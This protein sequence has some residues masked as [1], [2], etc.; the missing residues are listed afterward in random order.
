M[1]SC[2]VVDDEPLALSQMESYVKK[3]KLL[4]LKGCFISAV[5]ALDF[6]RENHID[7]L[8]VDIN[9]PELTGFELVDAIPFDVKKVFT[10]AYR[11]FALEGFQADAADYLL[12]PISYAK[13]A[14]SVEKVSQRYFINK[15]QEGSSVVDDSIFVRSEYKSIRIDLADID[16]IESKKE[17]M[18]I[19]LSSGEAITTY[20]SLNY[21]MRKL[22]DK[23][24]MRIHR[25]YVINKNAVKVV[26]RNN[27]VFGKNAVPISESAKEEFQKFIDDNKL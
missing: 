2:I 12:K 23:G 24:F 27:I 14:K 22:A 3:S 1:I 25:S 5:E 18:D 19:V 21:L 7:L 10:T 13:F 4:D 6:I 9:M 17:Y 11:E 26:E 20:G 8:F 16:Y 15:K